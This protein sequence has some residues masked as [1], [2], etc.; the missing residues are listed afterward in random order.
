MPHGFI[1]GGGRGL[2]GEIAHWAR[3][4]LMSSIPN[5]HIKSQ[6]CATVA[7]TL[8]NGEG[9]TLELT[10]V[11][12]RN[13][14]SKNK[15]ESGWAR[16]MGFAHYSSVPSLRTSPEISLGKISKKKKTSSAHQPLHSFTPSPNSGI[17]VQVL[18]HPCSF[19]LFSRYYLKSFSGFWPGWAFPAMVN[20]HMLYM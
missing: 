13:S 3:D 7:S 6:G 17:H 11:Q 9:M 12:V 4:H 5:T 18:K 10:Q 15:T 20:V 16:T 2:V 1:H 8:G 14:V 19:R